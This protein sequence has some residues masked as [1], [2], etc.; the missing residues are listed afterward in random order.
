M[1]FYQARLPSLLW[2]SLAF[3][4]L[5]LSVGRYWRHHLHDGFAL[6]QGIT[7]L[8]IFCVWTVLLTTRWTFTAT[9]LLQRRAIWQQAVP[10]ESI[11]SVEPPLGRRREVAVIVYGGNAPLTQVQ[12]L[13]VQPDDFSGFLAELERRAPRAAFHV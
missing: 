4:N 1:K 12:R 6:L 5:V 7:W 8:A 13:T 3:V 11:T 9:S 2:M 10:Y